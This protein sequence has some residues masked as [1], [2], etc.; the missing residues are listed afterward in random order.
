MNTI[1]KKVKLITLLLFSLI[2]VGSTCRKDS[3]KPCPRGRY[4]FDVTTQL[5]NEKAFY[6]IND[7]IVINSIIPKTLTDAIT[8]GAI[9][10]SNN[11]GI[12]GS[13]GFTRIDSINSTIEK[14]IESLVI[15]T[16]LGMTSIN[17]SKFLLVTYQEVAQNFLL[18]IKIVPKKIGSYYIGVNDMYCQ[19]I[20]GK[21]CTNANFSSKVIANNK[22]LILLS[23]AQIASVDQYLTDRIYC[24]RVQ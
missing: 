5:L 22:N 17:S 19:G 10:Y 16:E 11:L 9:N 4:S 23:N 12:G 1:I 6:Y 2:F 14:A 18:R 13:I 24:F 15:I 21:D 20:I 8:N 3:S 7:T